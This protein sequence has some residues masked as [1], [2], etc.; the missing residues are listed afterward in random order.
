MHAIAQ[1]CGPAPAVPNSKSPAGSYSDTFCQ[2]VIFSF[3]QDVF[4]SMGEGHLHHE[5]AFNLA[6]RLA[7]E[8]FRK[9]TGAFWP[10][11]KLT[12]MRSNH[13][14]EASHFITLAR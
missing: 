1:L 10:K 2:S 14:R 11:H 5:S 3:R 8:I 4:V 12:P 9:S 7:C 13:T 6:L